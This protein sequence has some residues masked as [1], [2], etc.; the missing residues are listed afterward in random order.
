M[1]ITYTNNIKMIF[2]KYLFQFVNESFIIFKKKN[3]TDFLQLS[4]IDKA[5]Y[6]SNLKNV[7][8]LKKNYHLLKMI[9]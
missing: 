4:T 1:K 8:I 9:Y 7:D 2:V 3:R 6:K 5:Q